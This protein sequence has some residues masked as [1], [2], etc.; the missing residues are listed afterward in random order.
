MR[1]FLNGSNDCYAE[2]E[3]QARS[4][5]YLNF[6]EA[7]LPPGCVPP[8]SRVGLAVDARSGVTTVFVDRGIRY[9]GAN[10]S[11]RLWLEEGELSFPTFVEFRQ[12][13]T[14][15]IKPEYEKENAFP[16]SVGYPQQAPGVAPDASH[17]FPPSVGQAAQSNTEPAVMKPLLEFLVKQTAKCYEV[18][19]CAIET[20]VLEQLRNRLQSAKEEMSCATVADDLFGGPF[21]LAAVEGH[22][23][24]TVHAG[25]PITCKP[26]RQNS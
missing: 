2:L 3:R 24:V 7:E 5:A 9:Y 23:L 14:S 16:K 6:R 8:R 18:E 4:A 21:A 15:A 20:P 17:A 10:K 12:W 25:P 11:I 22:R 13:I 19:V 1:R 26:K